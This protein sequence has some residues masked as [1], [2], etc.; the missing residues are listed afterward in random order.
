MPVAIADQPLPK[1]KRDHSA[2]MKELSD[3]AAEILRLH[4]EGQIDGDEAARKLYELKTRHRTFLDR[5][6]G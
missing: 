3:A 4:A 1:P 5:L 6:I 2:Q